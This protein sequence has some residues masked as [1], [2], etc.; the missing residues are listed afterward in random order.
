[1]VQFLRVTL[2][3]LHPLSSIH[4]HLALEC[5]IETC[6]LQCLSRTELCGHAF[7]TDWWSFSVVKLCVNIAT[8]EVHVGTAS[9]RV[10]LSIPEPTCFCAYSQDLQLSCLY[11]Y[12][13]FPAA[14][15]GSN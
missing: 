10:V 9:N 2:A 15:Q 13:C 11:S 4:S 8:A 3:A 1:M 14:L 7:I 5:C 6:H 12:T